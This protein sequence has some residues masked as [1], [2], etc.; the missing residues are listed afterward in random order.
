MNIDHT[1]RYFRAT[2]DFMKTALEAFEIARQEAIKA[3]LEAA[4]ATLEKYGVPRDAVELGVFEHNGKV[5]FPEKVRE[6]IPKLFTCRDGSGYVRLK[7]NTKD[8]KR[9][10][11]QLETHKLPSLSE[12]FPTL[13]LNRCWFRG[14]YMLSPSLGRYGDEIVLIGIPKDTEP[15]EE[16][17]PDFDL[18][19]EMTLAEWAALVEKVEGAKAQGVA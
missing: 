7:Q 16:Y 2:D 12:W 18:V 4:Y 8:G 10:L 3:K 19:E 11:A 13:G 6:Y 17:E 9:I 5:A 1:R 15:G 14:F